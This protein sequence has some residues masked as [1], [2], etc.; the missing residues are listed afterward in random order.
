MPVNFPTAY[1]VT[2]FPASDYGTDGI[3]VDAEPTTATIHANIQP[4]SVGASKANSHLFEV[5]STLGLQSLDGLIAI[6][7]NERIYPADKTAGTKADRLTY[8]GELYQVMSASY[9]GTL[10]A[11]THWIGVGQRIDE[12]TLE[13]A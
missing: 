1:T 11:L 12:K 5:L 4:I 8:Q 10:P 3:W 6:R 9:R 13:P 2:R 7:S